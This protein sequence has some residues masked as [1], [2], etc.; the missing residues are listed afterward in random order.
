MTL[1]K[2]R[3]MVQPSI[4]LDVGC[5]T[6]KTTIY[7]HQRGFKTL[8]V[9]AS[10]IAI[11]KSERPDLI[12]Q[13]DLRF[14]MD[15]KQSFDLVWCFEVAE[16]IHPRFVD[17]FV[18]SLIRHSRIVVLSAAPPGQGGEGH[19]NEQPRSYWQ[20]KFADRGY[21]LH[22]EW[23]AAMQETKEFYSE[24]MMVFADLAPPAGLS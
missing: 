12:L 14:P 7:L 21:A 1:V 23:T 3:E 11:R 9:E 19:F 2:N 5:G 15:L 10:E 24:N 18:D 4:V 8:G 22:A 13:H 17:T 16:H 20:A 6:G